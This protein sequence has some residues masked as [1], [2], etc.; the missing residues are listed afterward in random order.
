MAKRW[1]Q[2]QPWRPAAARCVE[3]SAPPRG[4]CADEWQ[5]GS[6]GARAEGVKIEDEGEDK[7]EDEDKIETEGDDEGE[8]ESDGR[9]AA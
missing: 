8:G 2:A 5:A 3:E 7:I 9:G 4:G 1:R 6:V